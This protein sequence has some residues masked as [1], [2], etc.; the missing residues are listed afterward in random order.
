MAN[1]NTYKVVKGDTLSK[2]AQRFGTTAS[3]IQK[4]NSA[5]IKNVNRLSV[6]WVLKIPISEPP[7]DYAAI[8]KQYETALRDVRNL[9]SVKK[10]CTMLE[11]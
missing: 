6:G 8:G 2:I 11:G 9:P 3:E 10:L 5:L 1:Y 7:K 4:A